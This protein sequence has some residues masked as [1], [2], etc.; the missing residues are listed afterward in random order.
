MKFTKN[1]SKRVEKLGNLSSKFLTDKLWHTAWTYVK[2][3][4]NTAREPFLILDEH[5]TVLAANDTF[6]TLFKSQPADTENHSIYKLEGGKWCISSLKLLLE[7]ILPKNTFFKNFKVDY[8]F[9]GVGRKIILFNACRVYGLTKESLPPLIL[10]ALEDITVIKLAEEKLKR[11]SKNLET[12]VT[13]R[14]NQL[15]ARVKELEELTRL[16]IG[17][18]LKMSELKKEIDR[19]KRLKE[20]NGQV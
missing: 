18:E 10:L 9:P 1:T 5:L 7:N 15:E 13:R 6:Y 11:Y 20:K 12:E 3:V 2:T 16:M 4:V 14:T 19:L 17:R 8:K